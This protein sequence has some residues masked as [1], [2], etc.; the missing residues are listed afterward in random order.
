MGI[1]SVTKAAG[2]GRPGGS[3]GGPRAV[4]TGA[5]LGGCAAMARIVVD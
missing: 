1:V 5:A 2:A 4:Q 3:R